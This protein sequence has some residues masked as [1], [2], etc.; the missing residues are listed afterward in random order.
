MED[1]AGEGKVFVLGEWW[2][3]RCGVSLKK[4]EKVTVVG[5]EGMT[6]LVEPRE[7]RS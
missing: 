1:F 3:A 5:R 6:L 2:N 7:P 4:G